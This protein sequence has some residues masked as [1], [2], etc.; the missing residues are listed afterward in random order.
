M[1]TLNRNKVT[2]W[3]INATNPV[4]VVDDEG[5]Y[6]GEYTVSYTR[7]Q[8]VQIMIYPSNGNIVSRLFGKDYSCDMVAVSN[9]VVLNENSY[10]FKSEP[11]DYG[12]YWN[13]PEELANWRTRGL[14]TKTW[15]DYIASK[16]GMTADY[17]T[18]YDYTVSNISK[19]LNTYN[20]GLRARI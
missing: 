4:P 17:D 10:L 6:T 20:Y 7:P 14:N 12:S 1:R 8:K 19:S 2:L 9:D 5:F 18:T 3:V 11:I 16:V 13:K 15:L